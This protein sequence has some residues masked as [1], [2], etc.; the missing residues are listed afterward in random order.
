M[1]DD[2]CEVCL[3]HVC[4]HLA[5]SWYNLSCKLGA[6]DSVILYAVIIFISKMFPALSTN[7]RTHQHFHPFALTNYALSKCLSKIFNI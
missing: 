6:Q 2:K 3:N 1:T 7:N 4:G 5:H